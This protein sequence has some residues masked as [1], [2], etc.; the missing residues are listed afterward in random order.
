VSK[1]IT[2]LFSTPEPLPPI[3]Y[4]RSDLEATAN[5]PFSAKAIREGKVVSKSFLAE[6]GIEGHRI[7]AETME[8]CK[9][10]SQA[11]AGW[12][13][14]EL[15]TARPDLQPEVIRSMKGISQTLRLIPSERIIAIEKQ[16]S[17]EF[18]P[19]TTT[20]GPIVLTCCI[21][22]VLAGRDRTV[23]HIHDYKTGWK[24]RSNSDAADAYQTCHLSWVIFNALPDVETIH[25]W[26]EQT[27]FG[28]RSYARLEREK[29]YFRLEGRI[30][31]A[32][33]L[34]FMDSSEAWPDMDK[35]A[36]CAA[37]AICPRVVGEGKDLNDDTQDYLKQ[38][39]ALQA[40]LNTMS[41]AMKAYN[42][43]FG[44]LRTGNQVFGYK[45]PAKKIIYKLYKDEPEKEEDK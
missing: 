36:W 35:C 38:F 28:T 14:T 8:A 16:Y 27:R 5:C 10:D 1:S 9:G 41:K 42:K 30:Q 43:K 32:V 37:T 19:A 31:R 39:I 15:L 3:T 6:V 29:D 25:F 2:D 11:I 17:S 33:E 21:D 34:R 12:L 45:P 4:D 22:I 24:Q 23:V 26:Y 7:L 44:E 20:R 13:E 40:R 18:A